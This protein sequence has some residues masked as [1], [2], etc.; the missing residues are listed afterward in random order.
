MMPFVARLAYLDL[1][2]VWNAERPA[3]RDWWRY[4]RALPSL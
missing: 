1:L 4:V 2:D 3:A